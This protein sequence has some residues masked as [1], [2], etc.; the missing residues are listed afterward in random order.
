MRE[1][2]LWVCEAPDDSGGDADSGGDDA[3]DDDFQSIFTQGGWDARAGGDVAVES[4]PSDDDATPPAQ[5]PSE[6]EVP[7]GWDPADWAQFQKEYPGRTPAQLWHEHKNL[8][9]RFSQGEHKQPPEPEPEP[10]GPPTWT[11]ADYSALGE[12][13]QDGLTNIQREQLGSLM[14]A[15][16]KAAAHWAAA[17]SHLM[18]EQEF[19]AVQS[20]WYQADP[21]GATMA[22]RQAEEQR[23]REEQQ[24]EY[25]PRMEVVDQSQQLHGIAL[26]EQAIPDFA[27]HKKD[28]SDWIEQNPQIDEHLA[29]LKTPKRSGTPSPSST[30]VVRA[31]PGQPPAGGPGRARAPGQ[32]SRRGAG[33]RRR[34]LRAGQQ[35]RAHR[36]AHRA[37]HDRRRRRLDDDI[38]AAIERPLA[39]L[40][41]AASTSGPA[42]SYR[43]KATATPSSS[44]TTA[45]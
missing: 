45:G 40:A 10:E 34:R 16:P 31:Q 13:P 33:S 15:D 28:F 39:L 43:D 36:D 8:R 22:W 42:A 11:A 23:L 30:P 12:I 21:Y 25:G 17:N 18:T 44:P 26:A 1:R 35:P 9:T 20:N 38:R 5:E 6:P 37:S 24:A 19:A 14:Q 2:F 27:E 41:S 4:P 29:S 32:G 3:G 7:D